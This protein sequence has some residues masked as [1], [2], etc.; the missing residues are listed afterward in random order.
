MGFLL[1]VI[2][3]IMIIEGA[4]WFLSPEKL[5]TWISQLIDT[6]DESLRGFGFGMMIIGLLLVYLSKHVGLS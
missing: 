1:Y 2:G 4:P 3:V 5:K 6:P